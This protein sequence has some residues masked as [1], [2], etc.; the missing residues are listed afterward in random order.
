MDDDIKACCKEIYLFVSGLA[1]LTHFILVGAVILPL[2]KKKKKSFCTWTFSDR[3][4]DFV[5]TA[6]LLSGPLRQPS[7]SGLLVATPLSSGCHR[8]SL[9]SSHSVKLLPQPAPWLRPLSCGLLR[10]NSRLPKLYVLYTTTEDAGPF[11]FPQFVFAFLT[12]ALW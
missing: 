10:S 2:R 1:D 6:P 4:G 12:Q 8:G 9:G 5:A 11:L 7:D 3:S